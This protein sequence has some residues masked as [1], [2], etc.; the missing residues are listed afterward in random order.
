DMETCQID[1]DG[2]KLKQVLFNLLSNAVKFT[3]D[4]ACVTLKTRFSDPS[5]NILQIIIEDTGIG[6]GPDHLNSIFEEFYQ[7]QNGVVNK[8]PGTGLGLSISRQLVQLHG[9]DIRAESEGL[10]AVLWLSSPVG[11]HL[12][13][14]DKW[15]FFSHPLIKSQIAGFHRSYLGH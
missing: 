12:N 14:N 1:A 13:S 6:I 9:G 11:R 4:G 5:S 7:I 8:T 3:P 2:R 10:E 15:L